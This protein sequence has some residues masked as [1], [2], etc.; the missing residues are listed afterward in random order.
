MTPGRLGSL[1]A[2]ANQ[3]RTRSTDTPCPRCG[4]PLKVSEV[5]IMVAELPEPVQWVEDRRWCP[6][7][8]QYTADEVS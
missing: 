3:H 6:Q 1:T 4:T 8:C 7:G 5:G 2:V